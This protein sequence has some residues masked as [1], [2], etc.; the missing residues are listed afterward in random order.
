LGEL[1]VPTIVFALL[2]IVLLR[3]GARHGC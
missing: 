2:G 1:E 3:V